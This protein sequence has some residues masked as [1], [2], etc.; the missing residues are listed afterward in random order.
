VA[1]ASTTFPPAAITQGI[2][3]GTVR[4]R[5]DVDA[6]GHV[7]QVTVLSSDPPRVFDDEAVRSL[8]RWRFN[9]GAEGRT[10][11]ADVEFRR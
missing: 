11:D 2:H 8:K 6:A 3:S 9:A 10:Y 4:A 1:R 7:T 5:L